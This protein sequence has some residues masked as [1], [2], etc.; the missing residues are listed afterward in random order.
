MIYLVEDNEVVRD[1]IASMLIEVANVK[2]AGVASTVRTR[3]PAQ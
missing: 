3:H 2:V 1:S